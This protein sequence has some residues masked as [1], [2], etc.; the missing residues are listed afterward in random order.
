MSR[1]ASRDFGLFPS[2]AEIARRLS[3]TP[4]E[5]AAKARVLER[6]GLPRIDTLMGG[7]YWPAV[8]AYF[9]ARYGLSGAEALA[10][11]GPENLDAL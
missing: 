10:P 2:E 8:R 3:Q 4:Q 5:W 7:R 9:H 1:R 6:D 11:D